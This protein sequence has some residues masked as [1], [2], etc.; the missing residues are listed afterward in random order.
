M[1][2]TTTTNRFRERL[3]NKQKPAQQSETRKHDPQP[4]QGPQPQA[5]GQPDDGIDSR[6]RK[7]L[8]VIKVSLLATG[9]FFILS[10]IRPYVDIVSKAIGQWAD[11]GL[12]SLLM[13]IPGVNLLLGTAGGLLTVITAF[14]LWCALQGLELLPTLMMDSPAFILITLV[15]IKTWARLK[16]DVSDTPLTR[17][18]KARFNAIPEEAIERAN[19]GRAVAYLIDGGICLWFYPPVQGGW[20]NFPLLAAGA[21]DY[22]DWANVFNALGTLFAVE[23]VYQ[24]YKLVV[25]VATNHF[26]NN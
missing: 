20:V 2:S 10:N 5:Q 16:E 15:R 11:T 22:L 14:L 19:I 18:L 13:S 8:A 21:W 25:S 6:E 1:T 4:N 17:R 3:Q 9:G 23:L 12:G 7:I 24:A 26:A